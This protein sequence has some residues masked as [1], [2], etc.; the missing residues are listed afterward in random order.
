MSSADSPFDETIKNIFKMTGIQDD[1]RQSYMKFTKKLLRDVSFFTVFP[2]IIGVFLGYAYS[3]K[4][5]ASRMYMYAILLIV[6]LVALYSSY[7]GLGLSSNLVVSVLKIVGIL[8]LLY[9]IVTFSPKFS[10][11]TIIVFNYLVS[12]ILTVIVVIGLGIVYY[13]CKNELEK[14]TGV[15]GII[16]NIIFYIPCLIT[17]FIQYLKEELNLTPHIVFIMFIIEIIFI[18]LYFY[19]EKLIDMITIKNKNL[20]LNEPRYL[21]QEFIIYSNDSTK[22]FLTKDSLN[23]KYE[24]T[25]CGISD[26]NKFIN[27]YYSISFWVY[28]N[29]TNIVRNNLNIFNY[30][31][32]K[33]QLSV[34]NN[35]Y[36]VYY[37][38]NRDSGDET[39][40]SIALDLPFQ[41]WN[42]FVFNY[43]ENTC[44]LFVN[45]S[46]SNKFALTTDNLPKPDLLNDDK[47]IL[48]EMNGLDGSICNVQ[49]YSS[50]LSGTQISRLYN[51]LV[52]KNPPVSL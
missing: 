3:G 31:G 9:L 27:N 37:T 15:S 38:N 7:S 29:P 30:S 22:N 1:D 5:L 14:L 2:I 32:G 50:N 26:I 40:Y 34:S 8:L 44:D 4:L 12:I 35:K 28:V 24:K 17:D 51:T 42:H 43:Y 45:G 18:L 33:P 21:N 19:A 6:F 23:K 48:G 25:S 11:S 10:K 13:V 16:V 47:F 49:F 46:F 20:L 41:K 39:K 36:I 52:F